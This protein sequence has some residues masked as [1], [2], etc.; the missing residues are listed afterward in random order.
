MQSIRTQPVECINGQ[1]LKDVHGGQG[2]LNLYRIDFNDYRDI[3]PILDWQAING[4]TVEHDIPLEPCVAGH[5]NLTRLAF[6]GGVSDGHYGL[7]MM[8]TA[9]H[10]L[11]AQRSWHFYDDAVIALATNLTLTTPTT[12]WTTLASRLLP[13]GQITVGFFNSTIVT[14]A[15][16]NY[17]FPYTQ[18]ETSNVQWIHVGDSNIGYILQLQ[19]RYHLLGVEVGVKTGSYHD[20][21]PYTSNVTARI[22]TLYINHG[23]GPY[24]LDYNYMIVPNV[25][26]ESMPT[27]IKKYDDEQVF[28]CQSTNNTFH[29]TMWP[30]LKRAAFVLWD[31]IT[32]IFSCKSSTF[33]INIELSVAGSYLFRET[34]DSF[35]VTAS[36]PTRMNGSVVVSV[37]RIG[38]GQGCKISTKDDATTTS[39]ELM[40]PSSP[41]LLGASVNVTCTKQTM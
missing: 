4:I 14:L 35:T 11:T 1:N 13:R 21:G 10:N 16:G 32:T 28:V 3:F 31:N 12:V 34:D 6:V 40:L 36:H 15:D 38:Y 19:Q 37:D 30:I 18:G 7:A 5:L 39:V 26:V 33:V 27:L 41:E 23:V 8:D 29:G 25:S 20:I 22:L 2:V 24:I 17:S 9:S